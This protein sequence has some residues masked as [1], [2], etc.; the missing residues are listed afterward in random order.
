MA[1]NSAVMT[2]G[3]D[4]AGDLIGAGLDW[5][6]QHEANRINQR[7]ANRQMRWQEY[8][9]STAYQRA[10]ADL[11]AAGLNPMLAAFHGG[12][13]TPP[14]A[15]IPVEP[16]AGGLS[17]GVSSAFKAFGLQK[18]LADASANKD[19]A[20]ADRSRAEVADIAENARL[21]RLRQAT[22]LN[23]ANN[24]FEQSRLNRAN[25]VY[26]EMEA[27]FYKEH[28]W[29][30]PTRIALDSAGSVVGTTAAP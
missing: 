29:L 13:S 2:G 1:G 30:I 16:E 26:K 25:A 28:P 12:S 15:S 17:K 22:E 7:M 5:W 3:M 27:E 24:A 10:V 4:L 14:G 20:D 18:M 11:K 21:T 19:N 6:S 23:N 8:M 9:S